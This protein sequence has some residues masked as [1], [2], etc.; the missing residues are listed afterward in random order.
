DPV[1]HL[2]EWEGKAVTMGNS[3]NAEGEVFLN[4]CKNSGIPVIRRV[5]NGGT[6]FHAPGNEIV[7]SVCAP[8]GVIDTD[9]NRSHIQMLEP[10][11]EAFRGLG[12]EPTIDGNSIMIGKKK[13]SGSAQKRAAK[14]ILHHGTVLYEVNE[15]E[16][17]SYIKGD[18]SASRVKGACSNYR[19]ITSIQDLLD[20]SLEELTG[21]VSDSLLSGREHYFSSWTE[22]ELKRAADL[23]N[24]K[25]STD[26]WNLR[27]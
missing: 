9:V 8:P 11:S 2:W 5:T 13:I 17:F 4:R 12:L 15:W 20:I 19:P 27:I 25:Y 1:I 24:S 3:Q 18:K 6:L 21:A 22:K 14:A 26:Q 16:M 7:Y 23:R 10:I